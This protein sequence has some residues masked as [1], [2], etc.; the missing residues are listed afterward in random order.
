[1]TSVMKSSFGARDSGNWLVVPCPKEVAMASNRF[2]GWPKAVE[3]RF[4]CLDDRDNYRDELQVRALQTVNAK[5]SGSA[6]TLFHLIF[7]ALF[8]SACGSFLDSS[9]LCH[10]I[11]PSRIRRYRCNNVARFSES[12]LVWINEGEFY[13]EN[14]SFKDLMI[15]NANLRKRIR[16]KEI[17][18]ICN[19]GQTVKALSFD[20]REELS[21]HEP[22]KTREAAF[23]WSRFS[24][25]LKTT[26]ELA[27][28]KRQSTSA[29]VIPFP[30]PGEASTR[31]G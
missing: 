20:S 15:C 4:F 11:S 16:A 9:V 13:Q 5:S 8:R 7:A 3:D 6:A 28:K 25:S 22:S 31:V 14:A 30:A 12:D 17:V 23:N 1:M 2:Q 19:R 21:F 18:R 24:G 27:Q 26:A 29:V 10:F